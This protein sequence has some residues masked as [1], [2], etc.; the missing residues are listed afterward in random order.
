MFAFSVS[1]AEFEPLVW[2]PD[3]SKIAGSAGFDAR[4]WDAVTGEELAELEGHFR[5][6]GT[7]HWSRDGTWLV[8]V[9]GGGRVRIWDAITY[10][11]INSFSAGEGSAGAVVSP[12]ETQ[13]AVVWENVTVLD[14]ATGQSVSELQAQ[15]RPPIGIDWKGK[16]LASFG[17]E[18]PIYVWDTTIWQL[19]A[20]IP[21]STFIYDAV[22]NSD[23]TYLAYSGPG[24]M[25][26]VV[27]IC[28][29]PIEVNS[30]SIG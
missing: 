20:T 13:I 12:D 5:D 22:W 28:D 25:P 19:A 30:S 9:D 7:I 2:S 29:F 21:V 4:I 15:H 18:E 27:C 24:G 10:T 14:I 26:L 1:G 3:G 11:L 8:T 16:H 17:A 23:G 6:V